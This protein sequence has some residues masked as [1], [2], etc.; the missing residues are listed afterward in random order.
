MFEALVA[1]RWHWGIGMSLAL[2]EG[3]DNQH[4]VEEGRGGTIVMGL[5]GGDY[6]FFKLSNF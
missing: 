3:P 1:A 5:G 2:G 6:I 4:E